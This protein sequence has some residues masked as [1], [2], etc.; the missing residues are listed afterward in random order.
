ME[1]QLAKM[2]ADHIAHRA[3]DARVHDYSGRG[4][5]GQYCLS[6]YCERDETDYVIEKA[7]KKGLKGACI[8]SIGR[9]AVVYWP[10]VKWPDNVEGQ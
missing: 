1:F 9:G 5:C 6:I 2:I 8:D 3:T 7:R 10:S 4:M